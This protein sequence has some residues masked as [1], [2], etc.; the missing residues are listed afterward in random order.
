[1]QPKQLLPLFTVTHPKP[2]KKICLTVF[3][4]TCI[5]LPEGTFRDDQM[6]ILTLD[7]FNGGQFI[8]GKLV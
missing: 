5:G 7:G 6:S 8:T 3:K 4:Y 1:M 2:I